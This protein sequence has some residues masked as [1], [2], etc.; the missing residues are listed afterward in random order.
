MRS[1]RQTSIGAILAVLLCGIALSCERD[2]KL[3]VGGGNPRRFVMRGNGVLTAVRVRGPNRQRNV[4]GE[5]AS[6]HWLIE[7]KGDSATN[8]NVSSIGPITYGVVPSGFQQIYPESGTAPPLTER[9]HYYVRA[10]VSEANGD[11]GYFV[12]NKGVVAF[13][14]YE[15][16][17]PK[18]ET[19]K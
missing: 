10:V 12:I 5:A 6:L 19:T 16:D 9:E 2:T 3:R 18:S 7:T 11:D 1:H 15:S 8:D 4:E 13:R 14:K 17:L